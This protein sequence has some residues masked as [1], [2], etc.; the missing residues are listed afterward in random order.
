[1]FDSIRRNQRITQIIL[2]IIIIPF[3]LFGID[4]Y[5]RGGPGGQEVATVGKTKISMM[6]FD[7][8]LRSQQSRLRASM[9][10]QFDNSMIDNEMF[11]RSVLDNL[12]DQRVLI[13]EA[14]DQHLVATQQQVFDHIYN[15]P[16]FQQDGVFSQQ[17]YEA[18]L[19]NNR[20]MSPAYYEQMLMQDLRLQQM[21]DTVRGS[22]F[23]SKTAAKRYQMAQTE[24]REVREI[25]FAPKD[26]DKNVTLAENAAQQFYDQNSARFERPARVRAEYVVL[27]EASKLDGIEVTDEEITQFYNDEVKKGRFT[28]PEQRGARHILLE[29]SEDAS[30]EDVEKARQKADEIV[31]ILRKSPDR[32]EELARKESQ[33]PGSAESGGDLGFFGR[34]E[35]VDAFSDSAFSL[36]ENEISDP[37]RSEFGFHI[38]KVTGIRPETIEPLEEVRDVVAAELRRQEY[39]RQYAILAD[40]LA[41]IVYEQPDSLEPA[42]EALGLKVQTTDWID[43]NG[44]VIGQYRNQ[45]LMDALFSD[46][47]INGRNNTE[48]V[49]VARGVMAVA[50]VVEY[51]DAQ[52]R[53][54]DSV[55]E[56]I[57]T[58]LRNEEAS[59][60]AREKGE[61]LLKALQAGEESD[62]KWGEMRTLTRQEPMFRG[63]LD[64]IF[65]AS[66]ENL[67]AYSGVSMPDGAYTLFNIQ[68]VVR[69][70]P[71]ADDSRLQAVEKEL[72]ALLAGYDAEAYLKALRARHKIQ[73]R[74]SAL[75]PQQAEE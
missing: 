74:A 49:E 41:N 22:S 7:Q 70:E 55:R 30:D 51:E 42:A 18:L 14:N 13:L 58:Q 25:T 52:I 43:R 50:R 35:M 19:R 20:N 75:K 28:T 12:I 10:E 33:D 16:A 45:K 4:S 23:T 46:D 31:A 62:A 40:K 66:A 29:V 17:R 9:G 64:A 67:P 60:Q 68:K 24:A 56:Q 34:T 63:A 27:D 26:F 47:A 2:G 73:I 21:I 1:M 39:N 3:A 59:R 53:P 72:D 37:V 48:A 11:R 32:F 15:N 36:A 69:T 5:F 71:A 8:E 44:G 61:A 65:N 38:I 6:E 57:E 54:F